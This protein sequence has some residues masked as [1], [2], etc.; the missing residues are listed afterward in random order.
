MHEQRITENTNR[1]VLR[2]VE[3]MWEQERG[4]FSFPLGARVSVADSL[5][6]FS[7]MSPGEKI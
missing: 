2:K 4:H 7:A 6:D 5:Q 3:G 1:F